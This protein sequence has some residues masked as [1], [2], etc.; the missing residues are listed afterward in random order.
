MTITNVV[1]LLLNSK[2]SNNDFLLLLGIATIS[3]WV[4]RGYK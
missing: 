3:M 2:L 1:V 4:S